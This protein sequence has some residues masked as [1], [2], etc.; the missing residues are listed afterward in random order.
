MQTDH[1]IA[2]LLAH[3]HV[4]VTVLVNF[5]RKTSVEAI[6]IGINRQ[7][8]TR[9]FLHGLVELFH[10]LLDVKFDLIWSQ[11]GSERAESVCLAN[12]VDALIPML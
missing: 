1:I 3:L 10:L 6:S 11:A 2:T 5:E 7:D 8:G 4:R 9:H 12:D